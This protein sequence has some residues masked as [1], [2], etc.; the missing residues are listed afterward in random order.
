MEVGEHHNPHRSVHLPHRER[1]IGVSP[2]GIN[3]FGWG[4]LDYLAHYAVRLGSGLRGGLG[5]AGRFT[6]AGS[7][8]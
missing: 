3:R 5:A 4:R 2:L 7:G 8:E 1:V 6:L